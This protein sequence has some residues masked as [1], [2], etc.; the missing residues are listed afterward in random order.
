MRPLRSFYFKVDMH[1]KY[2]KYINIFVNHQYPPLVCCF[3]LVAIHEGIHHLSRKPSLCSNI[4][5][6]WFHYFL[7]HTRKPLCI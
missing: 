5:R 3:G 2:L 1:E 6:R 4:L 7:L